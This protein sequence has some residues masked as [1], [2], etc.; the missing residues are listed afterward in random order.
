MEGTR[1]VTHKICITLETFNDYVLGYYP[2]QCV[3]MAYG[4]LILHGA[5]F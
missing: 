3:E 4:I 2:D 5:A 1:E